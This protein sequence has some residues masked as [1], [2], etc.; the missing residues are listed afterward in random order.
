MRSFF[1]GRRRKWACATLLVAILLSAVWG[2]STQVCVMVDHDYG[3]WQ[4]HVHLYDGELGLWWYKPNDWVR[5]QNLEWYTRLGNRDLW[6]FTA[7]DFKAERNVCSG[8]FVGCGFLTQD[9]ENEVG[10]TD[11]MELMVR[12]WQPTLPLTL[13]SAYLMLSTTRKRPSPN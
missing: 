4:Y 6:D 11:F 3:D 2:A 12:F 13:L 9:R 7:A 8:R 1:Q 10:P 5:Q